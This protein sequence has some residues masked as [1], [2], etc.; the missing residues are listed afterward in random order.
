[1]VSIKLFALALVGCLAS[2]AFAQPERE[3]S[4]MGNHRG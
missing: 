4:G 1:M 3:G 2:S